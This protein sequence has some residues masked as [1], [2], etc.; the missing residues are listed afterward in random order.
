MEISRRSRQAS[1]SERVG[2]IKSRNKNWILTRCDAKELYCLE[3][4]S[5]IML[6]CWCDAMGH[7]KWKEFSYFISNPFDCFFTHSKKKRFF[8]WK[9]TFHEQIK[10][11]ENADLKHTTHD[12]AHHSKNFTNAFLL[13][14]L[15]FVFIYMNCSWTSSEQTCGWTLRTAQ[16]PVHVASKQS[17]SNVRSF[18]LSIT[19]SGWLLFRSTLWL[20]P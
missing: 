14:S 16:D 12:E 13:P 6:L 18:K 17:K 7:F 15:C 4:T 1:S 3:A 9:S 10:G 5:N 8:F 11:T 2:L 20:R 19:P